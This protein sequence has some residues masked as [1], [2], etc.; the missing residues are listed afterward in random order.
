MNTIQEGLMDNHEKFA[1]ILKEADEDFRTD[2]AY[3]VAVAKA[4]RVIT[5]KRSMWQSRRLTDDQS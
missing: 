1:G 4:A 5:A 3:A 2:V